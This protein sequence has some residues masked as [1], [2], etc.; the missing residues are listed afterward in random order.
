MLDTNVWLDW[1]VFEDAGV[2]HLKRAVRHG[3]AQ[4]HAD[5]ACLDELARVLDRAQHF[6]PFM[7]WRF[8]PA[9]LAAASPRQRRLLGDHQP[10]PYD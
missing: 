6:S 8:V 10:G 2:S 1:L 3:H 7:E 5:E 4:I 9:V